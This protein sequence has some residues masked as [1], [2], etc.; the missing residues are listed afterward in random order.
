MSKLKIGVILGGMS[1]EHDVSIVSGT[2][3]IKNLDKEKYEIYPIYIS[4][5]GKWYSYTKPVSEIEV[6]QVGETL[7]EI[8]PLF[9][10]YDKSKIEEEITKSKE[11]RKEYMDAL[12]AEVY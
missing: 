9:I 12:N 1:T 6:L 2:S 4:E 7:K 3:V 8:E 11:F 5:E 10:R